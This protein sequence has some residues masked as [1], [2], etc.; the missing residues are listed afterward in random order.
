[1]APIDLQKGRNFQEVTRAPPSR[2]LVSDAEK[3]FKTAR[4]L[5]VLER[6]A[7]LL[8]VLALLEEPLRAL[9]VEGA[10]AAQVAIEVADALLLHVRVHVTQYHRPFLESRLELVED[11]QETLDEFRVSHTLA[12]AT[13]FIF[14]SAAHGREYGPGLAG[15][16]ESNLVPS[17]SCMS[18]T[19]WILALLLTV[20]LLPAASAGSDADPELTDLAGDSTM[21][22]ECDPPSC[23]SGVFEPNGAAADMVDILSS[24]VVETVDGY[25]VVVK[26]A[27]APDDLT[28]VRVGFEVSKGPTSVYGSTATGATFGATWTGTEL[29][30]A[31]NGTT[32][33]QDAALLYFNFTRAPTGV[34]GGDLLRNL[35]VDTE[36]FQASSEPLGAGTQ[37]DTDGAP[38]PDSGASRPYTF[39][40]P[41]I[42]AGATMT[43]LDATISETIPRELAE[44][45]S[46]LSGPDA[47]NDTVS[48]NRTVTGNTVQSHDG[49]A[50]VSFA[51]RVTN[52]G[53]DLDNFTLA[54]FDP[55]IGEVG[56]TVVDETGQARALN[57]TFVELP[58]GES[59]SFT[60]TVDLE[61]AAPNKYATVV[62]LTSERN[63]SAE[64][65][66][67]LERLA[68]PFDDP[69]EPN[70]PPSGNGTTTDDSE[71]DPVGG[72]G[73]LTP[74]AEALGFDK[75]FG[76]YAELVLLALLLLLLVLVVF[77]LLVLV[78]GKW[79]SLKVTPRS[80]EAGPGETAE[81]QVQV[82]NRRRRFR[83]ALARFEQEPGWKTGVLLRSEDG[84]AIEPLMDEGSDRE[85]G[86]S[87]RSEPGDMLEGTLR[88][89]VPDDVSEG[90]RGH[91]SLSVVPIGDNGNERPGRGG[92]ARVRVVTSGGGARAKGIPVRLREVRHDPEAPMAG[93]VVTTTATLAND[94]DDQAMRLRVVLQ[95]DGEDADEEI[96]DL[97]PRSARG[98]VFRW[99]A[100]EGSNRV[101]VQVYEAD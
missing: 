21:S 16:S 3:A 46:K 92:K 83:G 49:N 9:V 62:R 7:H 47:L 36:R 84:D 40:R 80:I 4:D 32:A 65:G 8:Q 42:V 14:I 57:R 89:R 93:D 50:S 12:N 38:N 54:I 11:G 37:T 44:G 33:F 23:L 59:A 45:A 88:V 70:V 74:A 91:V 30:D 72:L 97:P 77:L 2:S 27:A 1:M 10:A 34:S 51:Y 86:L 43:V 6:L 48:R 55:T 68:L 90:E 79:V 13:L 29:T 24:W 67:L 52:T 98:V 81:F 22:I 66:V 58:P 75:A 39:N 5:A 73:F 26:T 87:G 94:S 31:P 17:V 76:D 15:E 99:L 95:L 100:D 63:A 56:D 18:R 20:S 19:V 41:D 61:D 25:S 78:R 53:T 96:V 82:R 101:R 35:T 64:A 28:E 85:L 71:R 60:L 69:E